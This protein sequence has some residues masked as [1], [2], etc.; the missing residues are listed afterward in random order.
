MCRDLGSNITTD[1]SNDI[2][3]LFSHLKP[4]S[5]AGNKGRIPLMEE[6]VTYMASM[7]HCNMALGCGCYADGPDL[8]CRKGVRTNRRVFSPS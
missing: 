6:A 7:L 5:Q 8:P 2:P 1:Q 3:C 4:A